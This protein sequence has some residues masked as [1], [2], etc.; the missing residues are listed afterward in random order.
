MSTVCTPDCW[1][2]CALVFR[3]QY[4]YSMYTRL[5]LCMCFAV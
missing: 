5:L 4:E 1:Y 2:V 3:L